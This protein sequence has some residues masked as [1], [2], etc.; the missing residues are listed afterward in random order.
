M[1]IYILIIIFW[2]DAWE[3]IKSLWFFIT[4]LLVQVYLFHFILLLNYKTASV[5]EDPVMFVLFTP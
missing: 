3:V 5:Q 2:A 4:T 1:E